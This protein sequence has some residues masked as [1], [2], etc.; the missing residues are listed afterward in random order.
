MVASAISGV[1]WREGGRWLDHDSIA[2]A[3]LVIGIGV[4][5]LLALT[6]GGRGEGGD[7]I[8]RPIPPPSTAI[9]RAALG[10]MRPIVMVGKIRSIPW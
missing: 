5:M 4:V 10:N 1:G 3:V 8:A 9:D 2:L 6:K 7:L